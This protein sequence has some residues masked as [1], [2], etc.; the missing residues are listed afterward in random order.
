MGSVSG[1]DAVAAAVRVQALHPKPSSTI[2]G[3]A[4]S[5]IPCDSSRYG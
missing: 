3:V 4:C 1:F 2:L 5:E